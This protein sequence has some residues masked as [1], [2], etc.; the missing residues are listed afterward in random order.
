M[1]VANEELDQML[2]RE[3]CGQEV[4]TLTSVVTRLLA[5]SGELCAAKRDVEAAEVRR[6]ADVFGAELSASRLRL[7]GVQRAGMA[8]R[9]QVRD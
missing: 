8:R 7:Q 6:L 1:G 5:R 3:A 9:A 2:V 4:T